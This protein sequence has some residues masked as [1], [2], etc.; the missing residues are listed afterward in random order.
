MLY[1]HKITGAMIDV[2][3]TVGGD[4][5]PVKAPVPVHAADQKADK[6]AAEKP[7]PKKAVNKS[8]RTVRNNK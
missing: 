7:A 6:P 2:E 4:W 1:R 3:S 8:G 5:E